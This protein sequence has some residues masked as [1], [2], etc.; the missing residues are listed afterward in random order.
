MNLIT[1]TE[2]AGKLGTSSRTVQ[3]MVEAQTITPALILASGYLF[4]SGDVEK[5]KA[6]RDGSAA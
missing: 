3:R 5:I 1:T 6:E 4:D 2:A